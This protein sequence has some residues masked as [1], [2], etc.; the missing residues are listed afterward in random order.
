MAEDPKSEARWTSSFAQGAASIRCER[1]ILRA[2]TLLLPRSQQNSL[3]P[4]SCLPCAPEAQSDPFEM[5]RPDISRRYN[6]SWLPEGRAQP[7]EASSML[8]TVTNER[9]DSPLGAAELLLI[10]KARRTVCP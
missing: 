6:N 8:A 1:R 10:C 2:T 4:L 5:L 3:R 9:E 7:C